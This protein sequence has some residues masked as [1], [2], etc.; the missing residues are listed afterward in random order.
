MAMPIS[1][2]M[3]KTRNGARDEWRTPWRAN[4]PA[5]RAMATRW[6]GQRSLGSMTPATAS[7][8]RAMSG[9]ITT[10]ATPKTMTAQR[11]E[12]WAAKKAGLSP[13]SVSSGAAM[14]KAEKAARCTPLRS[15][16]RTGKRLGGVSAGVASWRSGGTGG[17]DRRRWAL[18]PRRGGLALALGAPDAG[19]FRGEGGAG[20]Q[21]RGQAL[22]DERL[23]G[24]EHREP[25]PH[26]AGDG[27]RDGVH[28]QPARQLQLLDALPHHDDEHDPEQD[29]GED[30]HPL[31]G[32]LVVEGERHDSDDTRET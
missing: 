13:S 17:R 21:G 29:A 24:R 3:R 6:T 7:R 11:L 10:R 27:D 4:R 15:S 32:Q 1:A 30:Q 25:E 28:G 26:P 12:L 2:A 9:G 8:T 16:S 5:K 20:H 18:E 23:D 31:V 14:P 22:G 19:P